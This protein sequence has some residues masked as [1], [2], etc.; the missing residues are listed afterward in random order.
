MVSG[1]KR[2]TWQQ[3]AV[4]DA[5]ESAGGFV[6]AQQLYSTMRDQGS[7]IGLATVYRALAGMVEANEADTLLSQSGESLFN[8]CDT[9]HHH[10]H[11]ICRSCGRT[12]EIAADV[13]EE[14]SRKIATDHGFTD[15][16]HEIDIF[17]LCE[18]CR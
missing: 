14:W 5:L 9:Q 11:I 15:P 7:T 10:H 13:I 2:K 6:S 1:L 4:R 8:A 16:T 3:A 12:E 17:G 18:Q